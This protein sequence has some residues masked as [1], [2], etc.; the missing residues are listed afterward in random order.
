MSPTDMDPRVWARA[1]NWV[2]A[3]VILGLTWLWML[4][5]Y[6]VL[7]ALNQLRSAWRRRRSSP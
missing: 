4:T 2:R 5:F 1:I 6:P 7:V 3:W